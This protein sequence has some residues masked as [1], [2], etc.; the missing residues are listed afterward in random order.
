[1]PGPWRRKP[2]RRIMKIEG[3]FQSQ[4]RC[5]A[6]GDGDEGMSEDRTNSSF[7]LNRDA[8]PLATKCPTIIRVRTSRFQSQPRCQAPGDPLPTVKVRETHLS[9]TLNRD[10][11]PLATP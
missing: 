8:R 6:P 5:Q 3:T 10:A 11:R 9:F 2:R 4:P 1:M 7:N